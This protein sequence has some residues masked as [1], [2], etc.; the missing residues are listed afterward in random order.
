MKRYICIHCHFYQ[1]ARENP[2]LEAI[3]VQDSAY[4]YH[5]WNQR[6]NAEC[7]A[8]NASARI[9][10]ESGRIV[11]IVNNYSRVSFNFGP[12]LLAWLE[13]EA[14]E[15]YQAVLRADRE[16][17]EMFSGHGS[18]M[19]QVYNHTIL[20]LASRSDKE[21][22]VLWGLADFR[23]RFG[24]NPE[25]MWLSESAV[26]I[27]SLE[28]LAENGILFT[29]LA[30]HQAARVRKVGE[31]A[32]QDVTNSRVDPTRSYLAQ[33]PSG[34]SI[35]LFFYDGPISRA[36]AFERLL[37]R[38]DEFAHR[39]L[40]GFSSSRHWPQ[41]MHIATDG[42]T[43]GHH[44]NHGDMALAYAL[45]YLARDPSVELTNYGQFL[46]LYPP[47]WEVE[48]VENTSW[49][50]SHGVER[51]RSDCGC[52]SGTRGWNQQWRSPLREALTWLREA[53]EPLY[54]RE[55]AKLVLDPDLARN[56]YIDV[57]EDRSDESLAR[58]F[59]A[60]ARHALDSDETVTSLKLLEL[61][62][63][64]QLMFTSC[65]WFFD[66]ISGIE[67]VQVIQYSARVLQLA[68]ELF[69][70]DLEDEFLEL[71]SKAKSNT[72]DQGNGRDIYLR[73]AWP[74]IVDLPRVGGHFAVSSLFED[75]PE[76]TRIYCYDI[77]RKS[78]QIQE[79]GRA[80]AVLGRAEVQS[81]ITRESMDLTYGAL[82]LGDLS[83]TG[84]VRAFRGEEE[85][86]KL[87][88]ELSE[89]LQHHDFATVIRLLD[90][91][92][93]SLTF[94]MHSLFRDEQRKILGWIWD[95]TIDEAEATYRHLYEQHRALMLYQSDLGLP[96]PKISLLTAEVALNLGLRRAAEQEELPVGQIQRLISEAQREN[97]PLDRTAL[98][99][100]YQKMV[101]GRAKAW[102]F[103]PEKLP[104][105]ERLEAAVTLVNALP[106]E[107]ALW[108]VQ[109]AYGRM[110]QEGLP[111]FSDPE[112]GLRW[113]E[114]FKGLGEK[115]SFGV[116]G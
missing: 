11:K 116:I 17:I 114:R 99:F 109:N 43:Y 77:V 50:C 62:R 30:P 21:T 66:D 59:A 7:Y 104:L 46:E 2:W 8:P 82:Y 111:P 87:I 48:I 70:E 113:T 60:H 37:E 12:T 91:H 20:P 39:L 38:G 56:H 47:E 98:S 97:V 29:V 25:G 9:L 42:E 102:L 80:R 13:Q 88:A 83:I 16:S 3:E 67:T 18:A 32:W 89:A 94:S 93:G 115:L 61:Q 44:H 106:F 81:T 14:P 24:R 110:E 26:D 49:S 84:G 108:K 27:E 71:L 51:W 53:I 95:S 36:V 34:K 112:E 35:A 63:Y 6:I 1:P 96:L 73:T 4:P 74:D 107:V 40:S 55:A 31:T 15:T 75:H 10:E 33:L 92:F 52:S 19:A 68:D 79:A 72:F 57:I 86:S 41:L 5:D 85:H 54:Q 69:D 101:E 58:F 23:R 28:V 65:G 22:Q 100:A 105:L 45:D 90:H 76:R 78:L 103:Q 64:A